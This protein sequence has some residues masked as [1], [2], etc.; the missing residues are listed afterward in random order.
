MF[1]SIKGGEA[2]SYKFKRNDNGSGVAAQ[3]GESNGQRIE[4]IV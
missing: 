4:L 1:D 3:G 2:W